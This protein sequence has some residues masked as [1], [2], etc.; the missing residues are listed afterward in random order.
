[1]PKKNIYTCP[2]CKHI[3]DDYDEYTEHLTE[4]AGSDRHTPPYFVAVPSEYPC[5]YA[6]CAF[7]TKSIPVLKHHLKT[8]YADPE[9]V[10]EHF[11]TIIRTHGSVKNIQ[12]QERG[13]RLTVYKMKKALRRAEAHH[14]SGDPA[15]ADV[16]A[17]E[18][19]KARDAYDAALEASKREPLSLR[20]LADALPIYDKL[21]PPFSCKSPG[22][23]YFSYNSFKCP[24][25]NNKVPVLTHHG[26]SHSDS[27]SPK[28][29]KRKTYSRRRSKRKTQRRK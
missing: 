10:N 2:A 26:H 18:V 13:H 24:Y 23:Y 14:S 21:K 16:T 19:M 4:K 7:S 27:S 8:H 9:E 22:C 5:D 29:G 3:F 17:Q 1:M 12:E 20:S 28:G 11:N 15:Y 25:C 6:A